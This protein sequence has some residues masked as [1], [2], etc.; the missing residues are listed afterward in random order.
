M[1]LTQLN[2]N[3]IQMAEDAI[4]NHK[5]SDIN[6]LCISYHHYT[7]A[8]DAYTIIKTATKNSYIR[9]AENAM[10]MRA[11]G[12]Y[13]ANDENIYIIDS[14]MNNIEAVYVADDMLSF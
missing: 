7:N 12:Y 5:F 11:Y 2:S 10:G 3:Y 14:F 9:F 4:A 8:R 13:K 6:D 1:E